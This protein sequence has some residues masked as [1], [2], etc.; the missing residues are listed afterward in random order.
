MVTSNV[1]LLGTVFN[2]FVGFLRH[3]VEVSV[4]NG[5]FD[6]KKL[7]D[8]KEKGSL[9]VL[10]ELVLYLIVVCKDKDDVLKELDYYRS[11]LE[12]S[13]DLYLLMVNTV[14]YF[15]PFDIV[16]VEVESSNVESVGYDD[17]LN[18]LY[19]KF[20]NGGL[21]KYFDV[22]VNQYNNF[23]NSES[24]GRFLQTEIKPFKNYKKIK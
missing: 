20:K 22:D 18:E 1:T 12:L 21:Y 19:V 7:S 2:D 23:K 6:K 5:V 8:F 24:I 3:S 15:F 10:L 11:E 4:Q 16:L 17:T 9:L 13:N 14:N